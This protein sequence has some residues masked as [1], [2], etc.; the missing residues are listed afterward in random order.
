MSFPI[1]TVEEVAA[2]V[3]AA[4]ASGPFG[5]AIGRKFFVPEGVPVIRGNNLTLGKK[6]FI[7]GGFVFITEEKAMKHRNCLVY[8][9]DI[10]FTAVGS[11]G[12]V[13]IIPH[14]GKHSKYFISNKQMKL[15]PDKGR[16][17]PLFLYY[18]FSSAAVRHHFVSSN[19]GAAVPLITLGVLKATPVPVPPLA[20]QNRIAAILSTYDDLLE[21]NTRRIAI[22]EEL[23]R[24]IF[25]EWFVWYRFPGGDGARPAEWEEVALKD[26]ATN[27]DRLRKPLSKMVRADRPG[28]F[29]YYGAAKVFDYIDDFIFD[30][31][32]L[33]LA[34]DGSVITPDGY[35][36]LQ[37]VDGKFWANNHTH[38][39]QGK[40]RFTTGFL[41][42]ALS[43]YPVSGLITGAAQPKITQGNMNR[44]QLPGAPADVHSAFERL[45]GPM[46]ELVLVLQRQ[47]ANLRAQRDLLLPR[48]VSGLDIA[49]KELAHA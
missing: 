49:E 11:L 3:K 35:P 31:R 25:D 42:L 41:Y 28:P 33:L 1:G 39:L 5:S 29:P 6:R 8:P 21:V 44:M 12:Q 22:L 38:I 37:L 10:V 24:R 15:T 30:G 26:A 36:V 4:I 17:N 14:H 48:L 45:V 32:Y 34:E 18:W 43:R 9:D 47:N 19:R 40:G 27:F 20:I 46:L 16:F 23:A 7:D 2:P 13:G